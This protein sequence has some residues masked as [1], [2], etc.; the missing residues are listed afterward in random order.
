MKVLSK[1]SCKELKRLQQ[2]KYRKQKN[3]VIVE[4]VRLIKQ[5]LDNR[6]Y[7]KEVYFLKGV[8]FH[9][10]P[11][12]EGLHADYFEVTEQQ[13]KSICDTEQPQEIACL[14]PC[15]QKP[16]HDRNFLLYLD[17]ISDPGNLGTIIRTAVAAGIAGIALSN[18]SCELFS[19]KVIRASLGS[20][21]SIPIEY[22][23]TQ[24][25]SNERGIKIGAVLDDA[26]SVSEFQIPEGNKILVIGSEA[27]GIRPDVAKLLDHRI[28]LAQRDNI[29]SLNAA[30][31][32][33]ILMY[34]L[35]GLI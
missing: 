6:I 35:Q 32:A 25:L 34:K 33:S 13:L 5:L 1:N 11:F 26:Q 2:K 14:I 15:I 22:Q 8:S 12:L 18:D 23:T 4:G 7:P 28:K 31:A 16:I 29:E 10:F 19:P 27:N 9:K 21:F 24:W 3:E 20:I 17:G 30:I